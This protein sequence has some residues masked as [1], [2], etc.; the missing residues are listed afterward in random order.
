L[1]SSLPI[2]ISTRQS[3]TIH[4]HSACNQSQHWSNSPWLIYHQKN[5]FKFV[6][7]IVYPNG[8][9]LRIPSSLN[10]QA[11]RSLILLCQSVGYVFT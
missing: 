6:C 2:I 7:E 5:I 8:V 3:S 11:L 10:F 4:R 9:K 1:K